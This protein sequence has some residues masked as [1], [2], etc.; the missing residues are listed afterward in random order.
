[1]LSTPN[2]LLPSQNKCHST[3]KGFKKSEFQ[4]HLEIYEK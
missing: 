4:E 3:L 2:D 1:M